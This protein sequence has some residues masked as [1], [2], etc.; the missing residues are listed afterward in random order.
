MSVSGFTTV[1]RLRQSITR[2]MGDQGIRVALSGRC[3]FASRFMHSTAAD[4]RR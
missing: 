2:D 4:Q 1:K 3:S